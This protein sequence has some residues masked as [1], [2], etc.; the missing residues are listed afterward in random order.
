MREGG[1]IRVWPTPAFHGA[2]IN[3]C[4]PIFSAAFERDPDWGSLRVTKGNEHRA[5]TQVEQAPFIERRIDR[6]KKMLSP[7]SELLQ[8][9]VI[10]AEIFRL[11]IVEKATSLAYELE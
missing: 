3:R 9:R 5:R 7:Q 4:R 11:E 10:A 2:P 6:P 8:E 1:G